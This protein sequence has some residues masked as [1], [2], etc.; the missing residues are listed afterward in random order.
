MHPVRAIFT[1]NGQQSNVVI[2][3]EEI[4]HFPRTI[5]IALLVGDRKYEIKSNI[6]KD[7]FDSFLNFLNNKVNPDINKN[8]INEYDQLSQEFKIPSL[9]NLV[10]ST[11]YFISQCQNIIHSLNDDS[12]KNKSDIE[13]LISENFDRYLSEYGEELFKSPIYSLVNILSDQNCNFN[14]HDKLFE[15]IQ[16]YSKQ[17]LNIL[18]LL[19]FVDPKKISKENQKKSFE[20]ID[21]YF[22]YAPEYVLSCLYNKIQNLEELKEN[23]KKQ[24]VNECL[25][26]KYNVEKNKQ[27]IVVIENGTIIPIR[28]FSEFN[29]ITKIS[30]PPTII[31]IEKYAFAQCKQLVEINIPRSIE[32]IDD[33][34]FDG[35]ESLVGPIIFRSPMK[36]VGNAVFRYCYKLKEVIFESSVESFGHSV[37]AGSSSLEKVVLPPN[38]QTIG[39]QDFNSCTSLKEIKIP[40]HVKSIE[41]QAFGS[42]KSLNE[43]IIPFSVVSIKKEAFIDCTNLKKITIPSSV[44]IEEG[45]FPPNATKNYI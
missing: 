30:L 45:A 37:F 12:I 23:E 10:K 34:A 27:S 2:Q 1:L 8:N 24:F 5:L 16:S 32:T 7:V 42:N 31:S 21:L 9:V 33:E 43:I 36:K 19:R 14:F 13:H 35:C 39:Y 17:N 4:N 3:P 15:Q 40:E 18:I 29:H 38:L 6:S 11:N 22:Q 20:N 41:Y 25:S 44:T 28:L 26:F